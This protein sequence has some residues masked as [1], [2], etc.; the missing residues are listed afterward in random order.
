M[1]RNALLRDVWNY[2]DK[3]KSRTVD[4]TV[5]RLRS[6]LEPDPRNPR[7]LVTHRG[8]GIALTGIE[9]LKAVETSVDPGLFGR[10][11]LLE[12]L[13]SLVA[14]HRHVALSGPTGVGT[15]AL[16]S[17]LAASLSGALVLDVTDLEDARA[18]YAT[19]LA[20]APT[21]LAPTLE[22]V[23]R[24]FTLHRPPLLVL[25]G[26]HPGV[27]TEELL[28]GLPQIVPLLTTAP[29]GS[30]R[31]RILPVPPLSPPDA[32]AFLVAE[33]ER[34]GHS[35]S[36]DVLDT[37]L[38]RCDGLPL[39]IVL[40]APLVGLFGVHAVE[41]IDEALEL[42]LQRTLDLLDADRRDLL[43][44]LTAFRGA[45]DLEAARAVTAQPIAA[46]MGG[47]QLL[48]QRGLVL[49]REGSFQV[50]RSV[51][52]WIGAHLPHPVE[53]QARL[54]TFLVSQRDRAMVDL[55]VRGVRHREDLYWACDQVDTTEE[56]LALAYILSDAA[57]LAGGSPKT[58]EALTGLWERFEHPMLRLFLLMDH[59]GRRPPTA[60]EVAFLQEMRSSSLLAAWA[61]FR[62]RLDPSVEVQAIVDHPY[63]PTE[64]GRLL[65]ALLAS[66]PRE[67]ARRAGRELEREALREGW[68]AVR[69]LVR[70]SIGVSD[71][72][73]EAFARLRDQ[74]DGTLPAK[75][76]IG[77]ETRLQ[78]GFGHLGTGAPEVAMAYFASLADYS[79]RHALRGTL[80]EG[81]AAAI[82][83]LDPEPAFQ[84]ATTP[85][86]HQDDLAL[87]DAARSVL[88]GEPHSPDALLQEVLDTGRPP[89]PPDT[90]VL[91]V[92]LALL[93]RS[94]TG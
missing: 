4:T 3:V 66:L 43:V 68:T 65:P 90:T 33:L 51:R 84:R 54:V 31:E 2:A 77:G 53:A 9:A 78:H 15:S 62:F 89:A 64:R 14:E 83:G 61:L 55:G 94:K 59:M 27:S 46:L 1:S 37:V 40:L 75:N 86:T 44:Q 12:E 21:S 26:L 56:A 79:P 25:D 74:D 80:L 7:F 92:A 57:S 30:K 91:L 28:E 48:R 41:G 82:A 18:L 19:L 58:T 70:T 50:L 88:A 11:T 42:P 17:A 8:K 10:A 93:V 39:E 72:Y 67:Q 23:Q 13:R 47:L 16:A 29:T 35:A 73:H 38:A 85:F 71:V 22:N 49:T 36:D 20:D 32:R 24:F 69:D 87:I 76:Y 6:K 5:H 60:S 81:I 34:Q 63:P 52:R 45:F